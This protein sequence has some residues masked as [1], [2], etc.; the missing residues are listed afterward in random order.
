[1]LDAW[2]VLHASGRQLLILSCPV[3]APITQDILELD[4][5][6][7]LILPLHSWLPC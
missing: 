6:S 5:P 1:M 3:L 4:I 7:A 2:Q